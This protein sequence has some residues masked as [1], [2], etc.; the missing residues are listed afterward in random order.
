MATAPL[1][2]VTQAIELAPFNSYQKAILKAR[3]NS[4]LL[5]YKSRRLFYAFLF[6]TLRSIIT[7]GSLIVPAL[8]SVQFGSSTSELATAA[9]YWITWTLSLL[10]TMSNG[11]FTLYK[12]DKKYFMFHTIYEQLISEGWQFLELTGKYSGFYTPN[13]KP[14]HEN[15]FRFFC[16]AIEKIK[17]KQVEEEYFKVTESG[18]T[19]SQ[20]KDGHKDEIKS[21]VPPTPGLDI[22]QQLLTQKKGATHAPPFPS[23][24]EG[25][26]E[27]NEEDET[28]LQSQSASSQALNTALQNQHTTREEEGNNSEV[29]SASTFRESD[30]PKQFS[31]AT[32][33]V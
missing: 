22:L 3:Y 23:I 20:S 11:I 28:I 26:N 10:V 24:A 19:H 5:E 13:Q 32:L 17:M 4:V 18:H 6:H 16:H 1:L 9:M 15:Q 31:P 12:V 29:S 30:A 27:K 7:I 25:S 8:L 14:T 21:I 2:P 33:S